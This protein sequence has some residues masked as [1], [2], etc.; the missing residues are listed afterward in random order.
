M[1]ALSVI[2]ILGNRL[3]DVNSFSSIDL[4][5]PTDTSRKIT[6]E[7]QID[8]DNIV[9]GESGFDMPIGVEQPGGA[10]IIYIEPEPVEIEGVGGV[11]RLQGSASVVSAEVQDIVSLNSI[12]TVSKAI[13]ATTQIDIPNN[14]I[15]NVNYFENAAVLDLDF[16]IGDVIAYIP[17][18]S[19]FAGQGRLM[20]GDE[21]VFY[22]RKLDDRF[23]QIIRGY[24]GTTEQDWVAGTYL[25]Q[26]ED[27]TVV[28]AGLVQVQSESDVSM[29]NIGLVGSGFERQ[30]FRQVTSP[31]DLEITKDALEVVL[32]PPPS[33]AIDQYQE[34]IFLVDP[35]PTRSGNTTGGHDGFVDLIEINGGYHVA[36]RSSTEVLIVNSVFGRDIQ[37][38]GNYV[39]TNVGHNISHFD[40]IFEDGFA[41]VSGMTVGDVSRYFAD[42][43]IGDFSRRGDSSY[44]LSGSKFNLAPPSIQNP[45]A[46]SQT[47][48][49]PIPS[50]ITVYSTS[51]F[52]TSGYIFHS[53]GTFT[54]IVKYTGKTA[55]SFTGCTLHNGSNQIASGSEIVPTTIV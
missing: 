44:L 46:M 36:R 53:N 10:K 12:S 54:G 47:A 21:V 13:T 51:Y 34:T 16:N 40:G 28:S 19:K 14:A 30:V 6:A 18:T 55:N 41:D 27:V 43:T 3:V 37:Y 20:I 24:E 50:T 29:V 49:A 23:Y 8:K 17:D 52:P 5:S 2:N 48:S 1:T 9:D 4:I 39:A 33:G 32:I 35:V 25:R 7:I 45:V 22:N 11:L 42:L 38:Q 26:I 15:S 31:D